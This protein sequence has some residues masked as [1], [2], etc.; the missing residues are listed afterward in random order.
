MST[1]QASEQVKIE[2]LNR[3]NQLIGDVKAWAKELGWSTRRIEISM[4]DSPI[5]KYKAPALL[6]Q[7]EAM[8]A[9]LQPIALSTPQSE[10]VVDL[11]LMPRYDNI[12]NISYFDNSWHIYSMFSDTLDSSKAVPDERP[13]NKENL[14]KS[15]EYM[16][17][18]ADG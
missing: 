4:E 14:K 13:L 8:L 18:N 2:W 11:Y 3:L 7:Q 9:L 1:V 17:T 16:K 5:G 12:A 10:G 6:L 15:L